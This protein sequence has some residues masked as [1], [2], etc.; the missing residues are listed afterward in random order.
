MGQ[1]RPE[2]AVHTL[3]TDHKIQKIIPRQPAPGSHQKLASGDATLA[4]YDHQVIAPVEQDYFLGMA[5]LQ[6]PADQVAPLNPQQVDKGVSTLLRFARNVNQPNLKAKYAAYLS[7]AYFALAE[8]YRRRGQADLAV[9]AY[10]QSVEYDPLFAHAYINLGALLAELDRP[11]E[12]F[13]RLKK[14]LSLNPG[15]SMVYRNLGSLYAWHGDIPQAIKLFEQSLKIDPDNLG[16]LHYLG[17]ALFM[18]G[19]YLEAVA[20]YE[21]ALDKEPRSPEIYWDSAEALSHLGETTKAL[22]YIGTGLR[23]APGN[24]RGVELL[25]KTK[26][27]PQ[28]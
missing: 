10:K 28:E 19:R 18:T 1:R 14:G 23:Y 17:K 22:T 15:D 21:S 27:R 26:K 24:P 11:E 3:F 2:D 25:E 13:L 16:A 12:A 8:S 5:Y 4:L 20:T 6:S 7:R 9:N